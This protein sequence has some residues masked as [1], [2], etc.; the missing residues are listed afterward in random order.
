[1]RFRTLTGVQRHRL[2][3]ALFVAGVVSA[4]GTVT[5]SNMLGCPAVARD[6]RLDDEKTEAMRDKLGE[7]GKAAAGELGSLVEKRFVAGKLEPVLKA[8]PEASE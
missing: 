7:S 6:N 1:M 5:G 4:I 8:H 2:T 3:N